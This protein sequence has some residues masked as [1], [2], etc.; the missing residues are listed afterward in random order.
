M[1]T[2]FVRLSVVYNFA[3]IYTTLEGVIDIFDLLTVQDSI[4]GVLANVNL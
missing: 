4:V 1:T 3:D 2:G